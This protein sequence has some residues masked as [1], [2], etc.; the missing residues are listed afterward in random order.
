ME[1]ESGPVKVV[2]GGTVLGTS[3]VKCWRSACKCIKISLMFILI[4]F[5]TPHPSPTSAM[6]LPARPPP[7]AILIHGAD[8]MGGSTDPDGER[9][10]G[11]I[12]LESALPFDGDG[13]WAL[14][15]EDADGSTTSAGQVCVCVCECVCTVYLASRQGRV[16]VEVLCVRGHLKLGVRF[17]SSLSLARALGVV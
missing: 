6:Y 17:L 10:F 16:K 4:N 12:H 9:G 13:V 15:V 8:A 2:G 1:A 7:Q 14:Y 5:F 3:C 11:R